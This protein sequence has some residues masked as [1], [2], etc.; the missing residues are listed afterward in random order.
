MF[1]AIMDRCKQTDMWLQK[2]SDQRN[3]MEGKKS[4]KIIINIPDFVSLSLPWETTTNATLL[5]A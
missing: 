1:R 4:H 2:R 3:V 5:T